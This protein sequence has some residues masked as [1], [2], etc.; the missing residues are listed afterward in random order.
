MTLYGNVVH[1]A[2]RRKAEIDA[3]DVLGVLGV[4]NQILVEAK[5]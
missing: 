2:D 1:E 5:G 3:R 4:D